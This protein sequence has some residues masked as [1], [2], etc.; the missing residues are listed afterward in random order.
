VPTLAAA[1]TR[2]QF[3]LRRAALSRATRLLIVVAAL[4]LTCWPSDQADAI[5]GG[6]CIRRGICHKASLVCTQTPVAATH[7]QGIAGSYGGTIGTPITLSL[8]AP[9]AAGDAIMGMIGYGL[10]GGPPS[11]I[12]DDKSNTYTITVTAS[13]SG[14]SD[15]GMAIF[16]NHAVTST[17]QTLTFTFPANGPYNAR[18]AI[19]EY[20]NVGVLDKSAA[21]SQ[22]NPG[23]G[24]NAISSGSVTTTAKGDLIYGATEDYIVSGTEIVTAGTGFTLQQLAAAQGNMTVATES[25]IQGEN[26]AISATFTTNIGSAVY[27]SG[28]MTFKPKNFSVNCAPPVPPPPQGSFFVATNGIDTQPGTFALPFLTLGQCQAAMRNSTMIKTCTVRAGTYHIT[29]PVALTPADNGETWQYFTADGIDTAALDGGTTSQIFTLAA[30]T[31]NVTFNGLKLQN[32]ST[33][34]LFSDVQIPALNNIVVENLDAGFTNGNTGGAATS[35]AIVLDDCVNCTITNN[36]A[37]DTSGPAIS[38]YAF[39]TGTSVNGTVVQ[40][41]VILRACQQLTDCGGFYTNMRQTSTSGGALTIQ[42]NYIRDTGQPG[43]GGIT[44]IYLDDNTSN[45]TVTGNIIAPH[46]VGWV[47]GGGRTDGMCFEQFGGVLNPQ[48]NTITGNICDLG[49]T[50]LIWAA[51]D[52]PSNGQS[53][54]TFSGNIVI[55]SFAGANNTQGCGTAGQAYCDIAGI[56]IQN[57]GYH[58]YGG[59]GEPT[60]G[61]VVSDASP[62]H[63]TAVQLGLTCTNGI[64]SIAPGSA[65]LAAPISFPPLPTAWGPSGF[66]LDLVAPST[67]HSC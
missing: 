30:S 20:S 28:V 16:E 14:G 59:G 63:L 56:T 41:N 6:I 9:A 15:R 4:G 34:C 65:V 35:A 13:D 33:S 57:N 32:C 3:V 29:T 67:N 40:N 31:S 24:A 61:T 17:P 2:M 52:T 64:Y 45:T 19:D 54:I 39:Q 53:N 18:A 48:N 38:V 21:G 46:V 49:A 47:G 27:L 62:Q 5:S 51:R 43:V 60:N 11:S 66:R 26:G 50:G 36:Y 10:S 12:T 42:K 44:G 7:V 25:A 58:N 1:I 55:S 23:T 22:T 8:S 37:H